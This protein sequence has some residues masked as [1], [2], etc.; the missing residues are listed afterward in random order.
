MLKKILLTGAITF[1]CLFSANT[2]ASIF[3]F[4]NPI[5]D[6]QAQLLSKE[7]PSLDRKAI[8]LGLQAY[9]KAREEGLDSQGLLTIVDY[10][11]PSVDPRF[12]VFDLKSNQLL[13][14]ELV[15]HGQNSGDNVPYEFSN[16]PTTH[17]S[18]LGL[19]MTEQTY[20]GHDGYSLRLKGLE[21]G[22]NDRAESRDIV[23][24]GA[25]YVNQ[26][27]A[28]SLGRLG[29]TWGCFGLSKSVSHQVID[30]IKGGTLLL[31]YYPDRHWLS[32]YQ[33]WISSTTI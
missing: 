6:P 13:F 31:A 16:S 1:V 7:A 19:Y 14:K 5:Q 15:A 23:V 29:R 26:E 33:N 28:E 8:L 32:S 12:F 4:L 21:R 22:F 11:K 27:I 10:H 18:S 3:D 20:V 30:T 24:H 25:S 2:F 9:R 17:M